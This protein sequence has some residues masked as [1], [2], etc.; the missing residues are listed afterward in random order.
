[1]PELRRVIKILA[2][3]PRAGL[4]GADV[5][6]GAAVIPPLSW[7]LDPDFASLSLGFR[8][9]CAQ[10]LSRVQLSATLWTVARQPPLS[11]G[12]PRQEYWSGLPFPPPEDLPD[13][14]MEPT[15]LVFPALVGRF[16]TAEP[17][18]KPLCS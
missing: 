18:G 13:P 17:L 3:F 11:M 12:F 10:S 9:L 16:F 14:G 1:M 2:L 15:C 4:R 5:Q 6:S 8:A 7:N